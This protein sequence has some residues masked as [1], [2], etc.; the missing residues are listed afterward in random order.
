MGQ[1]T[2]K[3]VVFLGCNVVA[4]DENFRVIISYFHRLISLKIF[5][6]VLEYLNGT[7]LLSDGAVLSHSTVKNISR[8]LIS[9]KLFFAGVPCV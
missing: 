1:L 7:L 8:T 5:C 9:F 6:E 3:N 4:T 2:F